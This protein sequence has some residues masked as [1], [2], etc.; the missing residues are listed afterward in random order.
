LGIHAGSSF[1]HATTSN[2]WPSTYIEDQASQAHAF[3]AQLLSLVAEGVFARCPEL[4]VV[5]IESGV[6]WLGN[7]LWR[8]NK[9]WRAMRAEVPWVQ[10]A[11]AEIMRERVRVTLQPL[12]TPPQPE[13]LARVLGQIGSDATLLFS[14]DFPHWHFEGTAALPEGLPEE[15]LPRLLAENAL[16]TYPR[17]RE[18]VP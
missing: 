13:A 14:T 16:Q 4:T 18:D 12:D 3:Q 10:R 6:S 8:A 2:G 9:T 7:F 17:L 5:L 15:M 11:P 1:R